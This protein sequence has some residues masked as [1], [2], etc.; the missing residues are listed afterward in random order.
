MDYE[1]MIELLIEKHREKRDHYL[2]EVEILK[3]RIE[4]FD[5]KTILLGFID[6]ANAKANSEILFI[7]DLKI[8]IADG[9]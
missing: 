5:D 2:N 6:I 4:E 8:L 9:K 7:W 1:K 3:G